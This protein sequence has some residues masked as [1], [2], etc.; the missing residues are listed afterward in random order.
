MFDNLSGVSYGLLAGILAMLI[1]LVYQ[2]ITELKRRKDEL[3]ERESHPTD[4]LFPKEDFIP[5]HPSRYSE[6]EMIKRSNDFYLSMNAR[7][8]VRFFS[9]ED[10]PDEV[11]DNIIRTAGTSP[12]GAHTEPWTFVVIKNKLL[13]AKVRE[14]IE[15][16]E[17]LNYKQRMGQKWV[18][19]LKPLKT[20]WIKEY[21]TEA[22]YLILVFKQTY[23]ITEDG[24]K[25][26]HYYNE[27]SASISCGFLLAAIQNAGL[28]ALTSTPLNAGSKLR[29]LVGRGPNEKIVILLPVGYP[30]KN[31]Q[32]PN[33]KRK[34]LNE[35]MIK[36]D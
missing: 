23:G 21:L 6:E 35:I 24:Q 11:I 20:N 25:K 7:R 17:E 28:V 14:I 22:P 19:D 30:S 13:K 8:S 31:C 18:D 27:I 3:K 5:Y 15:E 16:E 4:D 29:N 10:V 34:P 1:H 36:F 9:N 33:L 2:K 26:T 12:S 32:V